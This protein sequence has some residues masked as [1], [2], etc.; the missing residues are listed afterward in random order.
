MRLVV[1]EDSGMKK[2]K[3][4]EIHELVE[5]EFKASPLYEKWQ[6]FYKQPRSKRSTKQEWNA[7]QHVL[8]QGSTDFCAPYKDE[9]RGLN[10]TTE[11]KALLYCHE[12]VIDSHTRYG[13]LDMHYRSSRAVF[14]QLRNRLNK[15]SSSVLLIDIGCG[16]GTSGIAFWDSFPNCDFHYIGIDRATAMREKARKYI[17][18]CNPASKMVF[19]DYAKLRNIDC[20]NATII[21]NLCFMLAPDTFKGDGR[22]IEGLSRVVSHL[23][24]QASHI[25]LIYQNPLGD[26][27]SN[28][29][30]LKAALDSKLESLSGYPK[31][32]G[33]NSQD[34][35]KEVYCDIL[36][37]AKQ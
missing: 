3:I 36:H 24:L 15:H 2:E 6:R 13:Y 4:A 5:Q 16:P 9:E 18:L 34:L 12:C 23:R 27:H 32:I 35:E 37:R 7:Y 8:E 17:A 33:Y 11:E 31:T 10:F 29:D 25:Y 19:K 21:I 28:W 1:V 14:D 26:Y 30:A 20:R 22:D